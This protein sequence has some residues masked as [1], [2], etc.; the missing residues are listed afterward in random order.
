METKP[1]R[2]QYTRDRV[3]VHR[4]LRNHWDE[5]MAMVRLHKKAREMNSAYKLSKIP[6]SAPPGTL[7]EIV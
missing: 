5:A 3:H 2:T 6:L 1:K 7:P 4:F